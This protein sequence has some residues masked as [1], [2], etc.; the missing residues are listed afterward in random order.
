[1]VKSD[2]DKIKEALINNG[3]YWIAF[4]GDSLTSCEWIHPNW[5]EIVEY[6]LKDKLCDEFPDYRTSSWGIRCFNFGF[7]GSTTQDILGKIDEI[8]AVKPDVVIS[9]MGGNDPTLGISV[10]KSKENIENILKELEENKIEVF[11]ATSLAEKRTERNDEYEC[12]RKAT[13]EIKTKENQKIFDMY[14]EYNKCDLDK[15]YTLITDEYKDRGFDTDPGHPNQLG[16]AY[17]AKI[18]LKEIWGIEFDPEKYIETT[19]KGEK[20]PKY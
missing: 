9:L 15:F 10:E 17:I 7:D 1:M 3:K 8:K 11:W 6:V 20:Y 16:N 13:M 2:M 14:S 19:L 4:V 12:Y 5:R 18:V